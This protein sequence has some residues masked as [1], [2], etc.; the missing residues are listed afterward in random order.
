M[1]ENASADVGR[2]RARLQRLIDTFQ[3]S[4]AFVH[5]TP[6]GG[7][8][9]RG[10]GSFT[11]DFE[12]TIMY[13]TSDMRTPE[14]LPVHTGVNLKQREGKKGHGWQ[15]VL[16]VVV[17]GR[18]KWGNDETSCVA[19][20]YGGKTK[21]KGFHCTKTERVFLD[22][23]FDALVDCPVLPPAGL[24]ASITKAAHID[25]V[26]S[27]MKTR[28]IDADEDATK[29]DNRFRAAFKRAGDALKAGGVIG[30]SKPL[31]WY[32]GKPIAGMA[33]MV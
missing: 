33:P 19:V 9:P 15:F 10:H 32:S 17:V 25:E 28:Y 30:F 11:A 26:R 8:T 7:S 12:T 21:E 6:K 22:A 20:P 2:V 16:P 4:T 14:G 27:R 13:A 5:H 29:A 31:F 23:L 1:N 18:N 24:P 3:V